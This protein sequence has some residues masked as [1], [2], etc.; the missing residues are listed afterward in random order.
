MASRAKM[1]RPVLDARSFVPEVLA[2][3]AADEAGGK[4]GG[5]AISGGACRPPHRNPTGF[6]PSAARADS[7]S[8]QGQGR[9]ER[10]GRGGGKAEVD[11]FGLD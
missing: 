10:G 1:L 9:V 7:V 5:G 11:V 2:G 8:V 3:A 6:R 4:T